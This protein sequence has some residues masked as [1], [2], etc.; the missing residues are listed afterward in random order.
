MC[1]RR[2]TISLCFL[3][4][5]HISLNYKVHENWLVGDLKR[6]W[7]GAVVV[8]VHCSYNKFEHP[9]PQWKW[10]FLISQIKHFGINRND[11]KKKYRRIEG[12]F[13]KAQVWTWGH[14][15][16]TNSEHE[17][18]SMLL[19]KCSSTSHFMR[20]NTNI[21]IPSYILGSR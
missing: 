19:S 2:I 21:T 9:Y 15:L 11:L 3:D 10:R 8:K 20:T 18:L 13:S 4:Q 1:L 6:G 12:F 14:L 7:V 17:N 5:D 16:T